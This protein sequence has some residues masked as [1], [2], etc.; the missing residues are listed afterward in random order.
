MAAAGTCICL[1]ACPLH[2]ADNVSGY[3]KVDISSSMHA[4]V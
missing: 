4:D 3:E 2:V 1:H